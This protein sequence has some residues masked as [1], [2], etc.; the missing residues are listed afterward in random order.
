M[1]K[2]LLLSLCF[3]GLLL[4]ACNTKTK[5]DDVKTDSLTSANDT[6]TTGKTAA[7]QHPD[8]TKVIP[9]DISKIAVTTKDIGKFPYINAPENYNYHDIS[10]SDLE[11]L[12][13]AVNGRL[14]SVEGKTFRSNIY[15]NSESE[16]PFNN[17]IVDKY[18]QK[19]ITELGGVQVSSKL[20]PGEV[21]KVGIK[22]L[23]QESAHAYSIIGA[24][25]FTLDNVRT[26]I[27]RTATA[28]IWIEVSFYP[29]GGYIAILQK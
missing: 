1:K 17:S 24:N 6:A 9:F 26:Y 3:S 16:T 27:I 21:E 11:K 22:V 19:V 13:F 10:K 28:E 5:K 14:I 2:T 7:D 4:S 23:D 25:E 15:K 20:L 29:N 18:Y 8:T 12:H